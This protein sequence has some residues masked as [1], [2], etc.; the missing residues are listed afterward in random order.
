M[1]SRTTTDP[2]EILLEM[3]V[4]LDNLSSEEDYL[5]ALMEAAA[6]IEFK[7]KGSGDERTPILRKEIV[8]VRKKRKAADPKFKARK[9]KLN[10]NNLESPIKEKRKMLPASTK[11]T[12]S[13]I[14]EKRKM[15]PGATKK[16]G[17]SQT[18]GGALVKSDSDITDI[19]NIVNTQGKLLS[20]LAKTLNDDSKQEKNL[21]NKKQRL[22]AKKED[23]NKKQKKETNIEKKN[24]L[25]GITKL[26]DKILAPV[27]NLFSGIF[28][29][30]KLT[31]LNFVVGAVYKWFTDPANEKKVEKIR[32]FICH[33]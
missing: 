7:T 20:T 27:K 21:Q 10:S 18:K 9:V 12:E 6:T 13:P 2:I 19:A 8:E 30:I 22:I 31:A 5:S 28:D 16:E 1:A 17:P 11:I 24:G 29:Y 3:G 14:K 25:S 26:A 23:K 15:L 32:E 4:D 33:A